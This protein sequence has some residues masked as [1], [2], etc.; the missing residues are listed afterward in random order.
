MINGDGAHL[1][2]KANPIYLEG[3]QPIISETT[4]KQLGLRDG[5]I[6]QALVQTQAGQLSIFLKGRQIELPK[7]S[8]WKSGEIVTAQVK[9][10]SNG[11]WTL[12]P[13]STEIG[14]TQKTDLLLTTNLDQSISKLS[15][16]LF[17]P[18]AQIALTNLFQPGFLDSLFKALN[19]P[20]LRARWDASKLSMPKLT[21]KDIKQA[22]KNA[23]GGER[24]LSEGANPTKADPKQ[25][26][27]QLLNLTR[28]S[29]ISENDLKGMDT[30]L[31]QGIDDLEAA[32]L[33]AVQ[34][35]VQNELMLTLVLPFKDFQPIELTFRRPPT[36]SSEEPM[37]TV[38]IHSKS[39]EFGDRKSVV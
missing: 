5:Q 31:R 14:K 21:G 30:L 16:L 8:Q 20:Q 2:G 23:T 1:S 19:I 24:L 18:S 35:Q 11:V 38:N 34:S 3:K 15:T 26:I 39:Q 17:K 33:H 32:Q 25:L 37:F 28:F 4:A 6:V 29:N 10:S 27:A 36:K 12:Q 9:V 22:I 7:D 13:I